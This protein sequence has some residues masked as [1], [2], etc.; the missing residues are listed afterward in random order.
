MSQLSKVLFDCV[1]PANF[2]VIF[3]FNHMH[4][5]V[6]K[7]AKNDMFVVIKMNEIFVVTSFHPPFAF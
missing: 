3:I 4:I 5:H 1:F 7:N 2:V 6:F